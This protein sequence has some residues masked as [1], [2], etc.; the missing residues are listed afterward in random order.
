M[1]RIFSSSPEHNFSLGLRP[2][3]PSL[4]PLP[5]SHLP[6]VLPEPFP[7]SHPLPTADSLTELLGVILPLLLSPPDN[8]STSLSDFS[9]SPSVAFH[10]V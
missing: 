3:E 2:L 7:S 5:S 6:M 4:A 9:V 10:P 1:R 8:Y